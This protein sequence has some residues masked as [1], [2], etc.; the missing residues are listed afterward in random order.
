M[1]RTVASG[2][3]AG[4]SERKGQR[5]VFVFSGMGPQWWAMGRG[6]LRDEPVFR[7]FAERCDALFSA[8]AGWSVL[9]EMTRDEADSRV[10][11][12]QIAQP[13]NFIVQAGLAAL[14]RSWGVEPAAVIGHSVGEV[15]AA[16]ISGALSLED[17]V[18]VS[19]HR[20]RVQKKAAGQGTMLAVELSEADAAPFLLAHH[21]AVSLAAANGPTSLTLAGDEA[22][23]QAIADALTEKGVFNRFLQVEMAYHSPYMEPLKAELQEVLADLRPRVP[24]VP[25]V[26]TVTGHLCDGTEFD[27]AY[28]CR[29][30]RDPV[31][32]ARGMSQLIQLGHI[33]FLEV[34]PHPVLATAIRQCL[35]HHGAG[36]QVLMS[37][38]RNAPEQSTMLDSLAELYVGGSPVDW[39][40]LSGP[41]GRYTPMPAY[42]WQRD[43]HWQETAEAIADRRGRDEHALLGRR[44]AAPEPVW[45]SR[46]NPMTLFY[47]A[48]HVVENLVVMPGAAYVELGL[49]LH[50]RISGRPQVLLQGLDFHKALVVEPE[51]EPLL[52]VTYDENT[53]EYA[54]HSRPRDADLW[55]PHARG[56]LSFLPFGT[57]EA[58]P[59]AELRQRCGTRVATEVHYAAMARRGLRYG[60]AFQTIHELFLGAEGREV[61]VFV[62]GPA[63]T[64]ADDHRHRLHPT[65]L[66][67]CFQGLLATIDIATDTRVYVPVEI[68]EIRLSATPRAG[69]W[70][71]G[72]R[73]R[74]DGGELAGDITLYNAEG[75][76]IVDVRGVRAQALTRSADTGPAIDDCLY[77]FA[78]HEAAKAEA[79]S[80]PGRWLVIA[81]RG[82]LGEALAA[83]IE[84]LGGSAAISP[85]TAF[86]DADPTT[87]RRLLDEAAV[88]PL[89][90]IVHLSS[91]DL[92]ER[93]NDPVGTA[94]TVS[95]LHLIQSVATSGRTPRLVFVTRGAYPTP[96][97][98][99]RAPDGV[100][101]AQTSLTGLIRVAVNEYA[102]LRFRMI[103]IDEAV[104]VARLADEILSDGDEDDIALRGPARL[105]HRLE[106]R[107]ATELAGEDALVSRPC[108]PAPRARR[109]RGG[110][111]CRHHRASLE[112]DW[113]GCH[114]HRAALRP[115]RDALHRWPDGAAPPARS[116][117]ALRSPRGG[118]AAALP[119]RR[120]GRDGGH[121][122]A[123][124]GGRASCPA[125]SRSAAAG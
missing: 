72:R 16:Y 19:Y 79:P 106:R 95:A 31:Y 38:R 10:T 29:N 73:T 102:D 51:D 120:G 62:D 61:L 121:R 88:G 30:I 84:G 39:A 59:L 70:C 50:G 32:F 11:E 92:A 2:V 78:W 3:A 112:P 76:V 101:A 74:Y 89:D 75:Q 53:R 83:R 108:R 40:G 49:A 91:L 1:P 45:E 93:D 15:S 42:R 123:G 8:L 36:G 47:V 111:A 109:S 107:S 116:G 18:R 64:G 27:A 105:V 69:F 125:P 82:G 41:D 65:L 68:D 96:S 6:L 67:A 22:N 87:I 110:G 17:A 55:N 9:A 26:S 100:A 80:A 24:K 34:G 23:L 85:A 13:A 58:T 21:G 113:R 28:W 44:L 37:L 48:D 103:D 97:S 119:G 25:V 124:P 7:D 94:N 43:T 117:D 81:D 35:G 56:R 12:T 71:H 98:A 115:W 46:V 63:T 118:A 122:P 20:S 86:A 104:A 54:V 90:G 4:A 99:G 77:Q 114:R 66:D 57:P 14:W 52:R 5:P 33:L 60:P